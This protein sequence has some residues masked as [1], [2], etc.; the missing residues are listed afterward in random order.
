VLRACLEW[1]WRGRALRLARERLRGVAPAQSARD[2][3]QLALGLGARA[4]QPQ[5]PFALGPDPVLA[6]ELYRHAIQW[7]LVALSPPG[8]VLHFPDILRN[9]DRALLAENAGGPAVLDRLESQLVLI[10]QSGAAALP[11]ADLTQTAA[12][13]KVLASALVERALVPEVELR[14]LRAQRRQRTTTLVALVAFATLRL[15]LALRDGFDLRTDLAQ[16]KPWRA[17][18]KALDCDPKERRCGPHWGMTIFFHT[19]TESSP[20]LEFDLQQAESVSDLYIRNRT[21]CCSD[22][23][24]PLVVEVSTD[25]ETWREVARRKRAFRSWRPHFPAAEARWIRTRVDG[26]SALHLERISVYR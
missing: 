17:S 10:A 24:L 21:D 14:R 9:I 3:A 8:A 15:V 1:L 18:S 13:L 5:E 23:A 20:W 7:A 4:E 6:C 2:R 19:K 25:H 16:G 11:E 12:A 22:L 26:T